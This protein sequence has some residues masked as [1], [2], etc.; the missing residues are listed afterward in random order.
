M[1]LPPHPRILVVDN[2]TESCMTAA[3]LLPKPNVVHS[4][5]FDGIPEIKNHS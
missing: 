4:L 1:S 2:R 5:H 3:V